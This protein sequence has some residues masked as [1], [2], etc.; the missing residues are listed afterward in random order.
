MSANA[1]RADEPP[2]WRQR[3]TLVARHVLSR[4]DQR[5]L[6]SLLVQ[7]VQF[8]THDEIEAFAHQMMAEL[9]PEDRAWWN[10]ECGCGQAHL[11]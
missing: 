5:G 9:R 7:M 6:S 3:A 1:A 2:D 10:G 8:A 4:R 11:N